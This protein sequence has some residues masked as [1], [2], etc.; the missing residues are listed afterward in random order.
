MAMDDLRHSLDRADSRRGVR[1]LTRAELAA[2]PRLYRR[3]IAQ[4]AEARAQ[5]VPADTLAPLEA[6]AARAHG[7]IYSPASGRLMP[8]LVDLVRG[9]PAQ[10]RRAWRPIALCAALLLGAGVWG[11]LEVRRDAGAAYVLLPEAMQANA[12]EAFRDPG[13]A[14]HGGSP[15]LGAFYFTNNSRVAFLGFALGCTF[16]VGTILLLLYNGV[17]IGATVA[18]VQ[19]IGSPRALGAFVA[20]H[21]GLELFAIAVAS[22]GGLCMGLAMLA[23]GARRRRDALRDAALRALPLALGASLL[24]LVAGLVEGWVSPSSLPLRG[25]VLLGIALD[26]GVAAYLLRSNKRLT[27]VGAPSLPDNG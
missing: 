4:L 13:A 9:L 20:A 24:L 14:A 11:W 12:E 2:L 3:A 1:A 26:L 16:G 27:A 8:P 19:E 5:G 10:V 18:V 7:L 15:L 23:P 25:K 21:G 17:M 22:A 6:V